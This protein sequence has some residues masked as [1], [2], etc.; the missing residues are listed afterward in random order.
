MSLV[1]FARLLGKRLL[2]QCLGTRTWRCLVCFSFDIGGMPWVCSLAGRI[3]TC[4]TWVE[5]LMGKAAVFLKLGF[6]GCE[7]EYV[8][9]SSSERH[10]ALELELGVEVCVFSSLVEKAC[11][12]KA[13][14]CFCDLSV[15]PKSLCEDSHSPICVGSAGFEFRTSENAGL[16]NE[17]SSLCRKNLLPWI[18][19]LENPGHLH[20]QLFGKVPHLADWHTCRVLGSLRHG[21]HFQRLDSAM[22]GVLSWQDIRCFCFQ[23]SHACGHIA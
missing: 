13:R 18:R 3:M 23:R 15:F 10:M 19:Y 5:G 6:G 11:C 16:L 4:E 7:V 9:E 14:I 8:R 1:V 20:S 21:V 12:L 2:L 22:A 17:F